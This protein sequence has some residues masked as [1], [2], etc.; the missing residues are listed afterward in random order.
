MDFGLPKRFCSRAKSDAIQSQRQFFHT[1]IDVGGRPFTMAP[2][3]GA[4]FGL[5]NI[6]DHVWKVDIN[7]SIRQSIRTEERS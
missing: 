5:S 2:N 7:F 1:S 6:F 3:L 4:D